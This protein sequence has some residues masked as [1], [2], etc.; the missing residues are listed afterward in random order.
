MKSVGTYIVW[1][2]GLVL[3]IIGALTVGNTLPRTVLGILAIV[4]G[5]LLAVERY[6]SNGKAAG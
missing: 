3:A 5:V 1:G 6:I 2:I 4:S